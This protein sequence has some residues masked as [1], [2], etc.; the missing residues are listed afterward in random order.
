[1]ANPTSTITLYSNILSGGDEVMAF[2]SEQERDAYFNNHIVK[3]NVNCTIIRRTGQVKFHCRE[4]EMETIRLCNYISIFNPATDKIRYYCKILSTPEYINRN[5]V[6]INYAIDSWY[7][8]AHKATYDP[9]PMRREQLTEQ[10]YALASDDPYR[11]DIPKL[12]TTE[13]VP[14]GPEYEPLY[15]DDYSVIRPSLRIQAGYQNQRLYTEF[16]R[17]PLYT[18]ILSPVNVASL[19]TFNTFIELFDFVGGAPV[20]TY[21]YFGTASAGTLRSFAIL[22]IRATPPTVAADKLTQAL[23]W[24]TINGLQ[25]AILGIYAL[26]FLMFA[27]DTGSFYLNGGAVVTWNEPPP[28]EQIDDDD[29][30]FVNIDTTPLNVRNPKLNRFPYRYVR[31][32][33]PAGDVKEYKIERF[34]NA[35]NGVR[36]MLAGNITGVPTLAVVPIDYQIADAESFSPMAFT[37]RLNYNER[38]EY[39]GYLQTAYSIDSYLAYIA[40]CYSTVF[41][42]KTSPDM[43]ADNIRRNAAVMSA[44]AGVISSAGNT[45]KSALTLDVDGAVAGAL[46]TTAAAGGLMAAEFD[47]EAYKGRVNTAEQVRKSVTPENASSTF[48]HSTFFEPGRINNVAHAY[49]PGASAGFMSYELYQ[50]APHYRVVGMADEYTATVDEYFTNYGYRCVEIKVPA[51]VEYI[52]GGTDPEKL[53]QFLTNS[54]G[55]K[56]SFCQTLAATVKGIPINDARAIEAML[57]GGVRFVKYEG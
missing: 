47:R 15:E 31:V 26:P 3:S 54:N 5:T 27:L 14:T 1:M 57:N 36:L 20:D 19:P 53:P 51:I 11:M 48:A 33:T 43:L 16:V 34:H 42:G 22:G 8:Y 28:L 12:Q 41:D 37:E 45:L 6:L 13:E 56:V 21:P 25:D 50:H 17:T 32:T 46:N 38:I 44:G 39:T 18:I 24:L 40:N 35:V 55:D 29:Y 2:R 9:T 4:S 7:T 30:H 49:R 10:E 52:K 23:D